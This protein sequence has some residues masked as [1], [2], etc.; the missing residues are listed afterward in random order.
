M[1]FS[2]SDAGLVWA[3]TGLDITADIIARSTQARRVEAAEP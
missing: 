2:Q 3:D 1:V